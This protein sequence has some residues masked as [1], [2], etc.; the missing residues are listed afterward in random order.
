MSK[1][2]VPQL[3]NK[4]T[5]CPVLYSVSHTVVCHVNIQVNLKFRVKGESSILPGY[6]NPSGE[7]GLEVGIQEGISLRGCGERGWGQ[8]GSVC[9]SP[10]RLQCWPCRARDGTGVC[11]LGRYLGISRT[12]GPCWNLS[13]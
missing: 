1:L 10:A 3:A 11:S 9:G 5:G 2:G 12:W 8:T 13:L 4:N 7:N 6:P